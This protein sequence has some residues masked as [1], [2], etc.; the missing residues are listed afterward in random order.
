[1]LKEN[2]EEEISEDRWKWGVKVSAGG[3][4]KWGT[5]DLRG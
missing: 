1:M 4:K 5:S 3:E 2:D